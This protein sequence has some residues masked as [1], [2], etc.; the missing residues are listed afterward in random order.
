VGTPEGTRL[1]S[2]FMDYWLSH[3]KTP[4]SCDNSHSWRVFK[5]LLCTL[6]CGRLL[7][8]ALVSTRHTWLDHSMVTCMLKTKCYR[9]YVVRHFWFIF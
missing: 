4:S 1:C 5:R 3:D 6:K 2:P 9:T 7:W 8:T